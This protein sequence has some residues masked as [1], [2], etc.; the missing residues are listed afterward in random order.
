M[1]ADQAGVTSALRATYAVFIAAGFS[2]ASWASRI[3]QIREDLH[4]GPAALGLF[5][6]AGAAGSVLALPTSGAVVGRFGAARTVAATSLLVAVGLVVLGT[7]VLVGVVAA[8]AGL[9]LVGVGNGA[10]DVA[11]NVHGARVEQLLGRSVM[12]RFHA[13]FSVGTV[14]GALLGA[15]MVALHVGV[16][17]HLVGVAVLVGLVVP[18]ATRSFLVAEVGAE[19][20]ADDTA[21]R[22]P[23]A[24]WLERRTVLLGVFV[25][26]FAF[27]EGSG[28]DWIAVG[29]IDGYR[30]AD[31]VGGLTF[32]MFLAAMT[33][34]RW[35]GT[36]LIDRYGR[37]PVIRIAAVVALVGLLVFVFGN[38]LPLGIAGVLLWGAGT[39]LGFPLGMT[40]ASD[41]P[42]H[43]AAR[44]SV[45]ASIGYCAFLAGPP[46]VG[47]LAEQ[48][49]ILHALTLVAGLLAVAALLAG[50]VDELPRPDPAD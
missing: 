29:T 32:A 31:V 6:L 49:T 48:S 5:L 45:V 16:T 37:V 39:A 41:D 15:V 4:L 33:T 46:L 1:P 40:A 2:F 20:P 14:G 25:L 7:G 42:S 27:S 19:E 47:F 11:M 28:N 24:A 38:W 8:A 44:V 30:T 35:F 13:G 17:A 22:R 21:R 12:P 43:A 34:V 18:L 3:P 9:F 10:W 23:W 36:G 50:N 26:A